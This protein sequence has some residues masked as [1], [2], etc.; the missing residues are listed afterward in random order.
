MEGQRSANILP[1][2]VISLEQEA[3]AR[4]S[5]ARAF[6]E[7]ED[8]AR[9][10]ESLGVFYCADEYV[11]NQI[12]DALRAEVL[13]RTGSLLRRVADRN[14][15]NDDIERA[16]T[17]LFEALQLFRKIGDRNKTGEALVALAASY[18]SAGNYVRCRHLL[19][20]P[21]FAELDAPVVNANRLYML[22]IVARSEKMYR[23]SASLFR[24]V[25]AYCETIPSKALTCK[26]HGALG[27]SLLLQAEKEGKPEHINEALFHY[28]ISSQQAEESGNLRHAGFI[29]NNL[30]YIFFKHDRVDEAH[31]HLNRAR[32]IFEKLQDISCIAQVDD[33]RAQ[34]LNAEGHYAEAAALIR[35]SIH[36]FEITGESA[37]LA[38]SLLTLCSSLV[39][40]GQIDEAAA[41]AARAAE[42]FSLNEIVNGEGRAQLALAEIFSSNI[43]PPLSKLLRAFLRAARLLASEEDAKILR[44]I[45]HI[46]QRVG[47]LTAD[48]HMAQVPKNAKAAPVA[49]G[50]LWDE[51]LTLEDAKARVEEWYL[52]RLILEH[53][54]LEAIAQ[55]LGLTAEGV[56]QKIARYPQL[57]AL[58]RAIRDSNVAPLNARRRARRPI[59][60][61]LHET[62]NHLAALGP[63]GGD[64][65]GVEPC[66]NVMP[67]E[68]VAVRI[69]GVAYA[70]YLDVAEEATKLHSGH[71]DYPP[72]P[73]KG[74]EVMG[75]VVGYWPKGKGEQKMKPLKIS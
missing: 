9:A 73:C 44:R 75:V 53:G 61:R 25:V 21:V 55:E 31:E 74:S 66:E 3:E 8:F 60:V 42:I 34:V 30:G 6:E 16:K 23:E 45:E 58:R 15:I 48:S 70:G 19:N 72:I 12:S 7:V 67:E 57:D 68:L 35:R 47:E 22:G 29:T 56:R 20:E 41:C 69:Q 38:E 62:D 63:R 59:R 13:L 50:A 17:Y 51:G 33:T 49:G 32:R 64:S 36:T 24:E 18:W 46:E 5:S 14:R 37:F 65:L 4:C 26:Y 40:L 2:D 52:A 27:N 43:T 28:T 1:Y 11:L 10:R 54:T 39:G 71:E